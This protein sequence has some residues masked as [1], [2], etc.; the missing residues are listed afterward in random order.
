M[1][2]QDDTELLKLQQERVKKFQKDAKSHKPQNEKTVKE[3]QRPVPTTIPL[4]T[5][6]LSLLYQKNFPFQSLELSPH[7]ITKEDLIE[8]LIKGYNSER[9][10]QKIKA[11]NEDE[12]KNFSYNISAILKELLKLDFIELDA[13]H[14]IYI[15]KSGI[16]FIQ[17][18]TYL[19][20][21]PAD[22]YEAYQIYIQLGAL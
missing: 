16:L 13:E 4:T 5:Q 22:L 7:G 19:M 9:E 18:T 12:T 3:F 10:L 8:T 15:R 1:T 17:S 2:F 21:N 20:R 6:I 14:K 11:M